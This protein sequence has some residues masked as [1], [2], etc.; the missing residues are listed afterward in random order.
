MATLRFGATCVYKIQK[1]Y[2]LDLLGRLSKVYQVTSQTQLSRPIPLR[3]Y[4][5]GNTDSA[6]NNNLY[7]VTAAADDL[8]S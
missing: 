1:K 7:D 4:T 3:H 5:S 8:L 2:L 6:G